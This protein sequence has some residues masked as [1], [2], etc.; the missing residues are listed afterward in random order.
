MSRRAY[1]V[2]PMPLD[3]VYLEPLA[4]ALTAN[5]DHEVAGS[6]PVVITDILSSAN[7][8]PVPALAKV[9]VERSLPSPSLKLSPPSPYVTRSIGKLS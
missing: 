3:Q 2:Q 7:I 6:E 9:R 5:S 4:F 1:V 8:N